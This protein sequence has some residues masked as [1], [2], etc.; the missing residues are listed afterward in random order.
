MEAEGAGE[1]K[2]QRRNTADSRTSKSILLGAGGGIREG[3]HGCVRSVPGPARAGLS[4]QTRGTVGATERIISGRSDLFEVYWRRFSERWMC[5]CV[6]LWG[7]EGE[8]EVNLVWTSFKLSKKQYKAFEIKR[9]STF[10]HTLFQH[11]LH[12][13]GTLR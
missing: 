12:S 4:Y 13:H 3:G 2:V 1:T 9:T 8:R 6:F 10:C 11:S 5:L 7:G